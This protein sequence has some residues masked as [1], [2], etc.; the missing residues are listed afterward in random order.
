M[1]ILICFACRY[2]YQD[3]PIQ[4]TPITT[5]IILQ[6]IHKKIN[7]LGDKTAVILRFNPWLC[8]DPKQ[9]INQFF[10]QLASAIKLKNQIVKKH[11]N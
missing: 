4:E 6:N 1:H 9:L 8:A 10:K 11:G 7:I 5:C 2:I 3:I